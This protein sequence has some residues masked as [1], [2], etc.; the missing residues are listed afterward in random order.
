VARLG[1]QHPSIAAAL[2]ELLTERDAIEAE[3]FL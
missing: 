1:K 2:S 3:G